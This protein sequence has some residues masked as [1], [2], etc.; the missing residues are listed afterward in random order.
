MQFS[1]LG[2]IFAQVGFARFCRGWPKF[3]NISALAAWLFCMFA[4][5]AFWLPFAPSPT[6]ATLPREPASAPFYHGDS[7]D[8]Q[9]H[10]GLQDR[11]HDCQKMIFWP[12]RISRFQHPRLNSLWCLSVFVGA[13]KKTSSLRCF[14]VIRAVLRE[15]EA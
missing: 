8:E 1:L 13:E 11:E 2:A 6:A 5:D 9:R 15:Q 14:A 12:R 7:A 4:H 3:I 10:H